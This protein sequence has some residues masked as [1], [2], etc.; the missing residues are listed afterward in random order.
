VRDGRPLET[1]DRRVDEYR[2]YY[3]YG[4]ERHHDRDHY[5]PYRRSDRGYFPDELRK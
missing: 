5:H 3:S 4:F 1:S 2:C